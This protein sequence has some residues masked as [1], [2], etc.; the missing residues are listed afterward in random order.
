M[1]EVAH[2]VTRG[3]SA[4]QAG[5]R[6]LP[7][8]LTLMTTPPIAGRLVNRVGFGKPVAL[9]ALVGALGMWAL[10]GLH[11]STPYGDIWWRQAIAGTGFGLSIPTL[12]AAVLTA[13]DARRA[14]LASSVGN[15]A[16]QVG[17]VLS[18]ALLGAVVATRSHASALAS[19][20]ALP[21]AARQ[22]AAAAIS[23]SG[24]QP[25]HTGLADLSQTQAQHVGAIAY[26]AGIHSAFLIVAGVLLLAGLIAIRWLRIVPETQA[27]PPQTV[28]AVPALQVDIE[29]H[30]LI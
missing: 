2:D 29:T 1:V 19:L 21:D 28:D 12:S 13:V 18:I 22:A 14:G 17:A 5:L 10:A 7:F 26:A 30:Q 16:R 27:H 8:T 11:P 3:K 25:I 20:Q 15:T 23:R 9:G 24:A 4:L 6:S